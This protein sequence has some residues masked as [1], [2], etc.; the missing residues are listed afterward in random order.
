MALGFL[1]AWRP[2]GPWVLTAIP[3]EG[4][5]TRT[6]TLAEPDAVMTWVHDHRGSWNIYFT[7]NETYGP[8]RKKPSKQD[9]VAATG[10]H[11]GRR[12]APR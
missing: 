10:L 8:V 4:G 1:E 7:V 11:V 12:P 6:V 2:G 5:A 9:I 3:V